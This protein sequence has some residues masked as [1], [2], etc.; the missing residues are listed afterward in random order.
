[1][2]AAFFVVLLIVAAV[3][4]ADIIF[5]DSGSKVDTS[6]VGV[7][8]IKPSRRRPDVV[9]IFLISV[10]AMSVVLIVDLL[11]CAVAA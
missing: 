7:F 4:A 10:V 3:S 9:A 8:G 5:G 1:M 11:S 2:K 6:V